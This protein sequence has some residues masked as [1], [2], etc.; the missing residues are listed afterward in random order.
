[1]GA[2]RRAFLNDLVDLAMKHNARVEYFDEDDT[3][4]FCGSPDATGHAWVVDG[5]AV[6]HG[7]ALKTFTSKSNPPVIE[8]KSAGL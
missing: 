1:M 8:G 2:E 5:D 7:L 3:W 6:L 4:C